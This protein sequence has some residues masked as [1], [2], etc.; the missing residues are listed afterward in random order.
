MPNAAIKVFIRQKPDRRFWDRCML[1]GGWCEMRPVAFYTRLLALTSLLGVFLPLE[2][3]AQLVSQVRVTQ[4]TPLSLYT[5]VTVTA[6]NAAGNDDDPDCALA[7]I[8]TQCANNEAGL[9]L[10]LLR[11]VTTS[12]P[13][14]RA[15]LALTKTTEEDVLVAG[16]E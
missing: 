13:T 6:S 2:A 8:P 4:G 1:L 3:T 14:R 7:P 10:P 9:R 11:Q 5:E 12:V 16:G 15:D